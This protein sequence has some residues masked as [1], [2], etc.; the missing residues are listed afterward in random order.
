MLRHMASPEAVEELI[1]RTGYPRAAFTQLIEHAVRD[2]GHAEELY[3]VLDS[4]PLRQEHHEILGLSALHTVLLLAQAL[5][6]VFAQH[7]A[8]QIA[9]AAS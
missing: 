8:A 3:L 6:D 9:R 1:A 5:D 2:I 4:L 7:D